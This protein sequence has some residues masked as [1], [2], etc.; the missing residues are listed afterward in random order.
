MFDRY[1]KDELF[2]QFDKNIKLQRLIKSIYYSFGHNVDMVNSSSKTILKLLLEYINMVLA[3]EDEPKE[4]V[5]LSIDNGLDSFFE[6]L[7]SYYGVKEGKYLFVFDFISLEKNINAEYIFMMINKERNLILEKLNSPLLLVVPKELKRVFAYSAS[8]FWSV[9]K[10]SVDINIGIEHEDKID[11]VDDIEES[12]IE[13]DTLSTLLREKEKLLQ[14]LKEENNTL[15]LQRLYLIN[16]VEIGDYYVLYGAL[17]KA[18]EFYS[19]A[20]KVAYRLHNKRPDSI[21]AK[22]DLSV[23]LNKLADIYLQKGEVDRALNHYQ[24][25]LELREDI[26]KRR[27]DSIEAKRDLSV[28]F[29]KLSTVYEFEKKFKEVVEQLLKA[30]DIILEFRGCGYGDFDNMIEFFEKKIEEIK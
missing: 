28:S 29:Y 6:K 8:D 25:G 12:D 13:D 3:R 16:L 14:Q 5:I 15:Y 27:P 10:Y 9:N 23:S 2:G 11:L 26:Q 24:S 22:R 21:E 1:Q 19:E 20:L 4:I 30:R 18:F 7:E 17:T